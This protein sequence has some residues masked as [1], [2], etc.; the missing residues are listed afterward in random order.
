LKFLVCASLRA[1]L[2]GRMHL[3]IGCDDRH[4]GWLIKKYLNR[5]G[6]QPIIARGSSIRVL[7]RLDGRRQSLIR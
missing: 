7:F 3:E 2:I 5:G 4:D 1:K 6:S